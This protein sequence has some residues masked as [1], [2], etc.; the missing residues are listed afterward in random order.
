[1]RG[2]RHHDHVHKDLAMCLGSVCTSLCS[3]N[4]V[5]DATMS[6]PLSCTDSWPFCFEQVSFSSHWVFKDE[7]PQCTFQNHE[8]CE[9][10]VVTRIHLAS[11]SFLYKGKYIVRRNSSPCSAYAAAPFYDSHLFT[12]QLEIIFARYAK[13]THFIYTVLDISFVIIHYYGEEISFRL[14]Q[15]KKCSNPN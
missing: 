1:M 4:K 14:L 9:V 12:S 3:D 5:P 10:F 8:N 11:M 2:E 6:G 13:S 7:N 15:V